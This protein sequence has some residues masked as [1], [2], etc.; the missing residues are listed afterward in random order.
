MSDVSLCLCHQL[1]NHWGAESRTGKTFELH[2]NPGGAMFDSAC[3]TR[4][5]ENLTRCIEE[6]SSDEEGPCE[7]CNFTHCM[8]TDTSITVKEA[9]ESKD[10]DSWKQAIQQ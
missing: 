6:D 8:L 1:K 2:R 7:E 4:E 10:A 9:L 3:K 5:I